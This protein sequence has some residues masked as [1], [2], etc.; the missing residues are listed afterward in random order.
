M[1]TKKTEK[2]TMPK[3]FQE[4]VQ[5]IKR[6]ETFDQES[7][8]SEI[9][10]QISALM[11]CQGLNKAELAK[12]L[13]TSRSYVTKILQGNANFTLDSLVQI[14][15]ALGCNFRPV[16]AP[17]NVW[18]QIGAKEFSAT[19]KMAGASETYN[20]PTLIETKTKINASRLRQ[21]ST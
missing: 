1:L 7:L 4:L 15:R 8:R 16:F 18:N 5:R 9:S 13:N 19:A 20:A 12:R 21:P 17:T 2:R 14:A 10:D 3:D 6:S 11:E